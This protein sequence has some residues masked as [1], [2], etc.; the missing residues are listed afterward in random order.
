MRFESAL[1]KTHVMAD[2]K[3]GH[4]VLLMVTRNSPA[5]SVRRRRRACWSARR[6]SAARG[7]K[8][9]PAP[10]QCVAVPAAELMRIRPRKLIGVIEAHFLQQLVDPFPAFLAVQR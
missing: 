9:L 1:L 2:Q 10:E 8:Q 4:F 7:G 5:M 3:D 6:Q